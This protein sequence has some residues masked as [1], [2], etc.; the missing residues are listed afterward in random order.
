VH[1]AVVLDNPK[2]AFEVA[3]MNSSLAVVDIHIHYSSFV[4]AADIRNHCST[5]AVVVD[6]LVAD[7]ASAD[8][9]EIAVVDKLLV[10][11]VAEDN[12]DSHPEQTD[13]T[14]R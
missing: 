1:L 8:S 10:V 4:I 6:N 13:L 11:L 5:L 2:A 9:W 7:T 3:G 14:D 12:I